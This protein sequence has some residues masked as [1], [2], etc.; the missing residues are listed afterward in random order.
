SPRDRATQV[1]WG[2][3]DFRKRFG[4][5][6]EGMWLPECAVD[7]P[8]LEALAAEGIAFSV[9]APHQAKAWRPPGG[10]WRTTA[11]D[12][13]RTYK[14]KLPSGRTIDLFFYDGATAQAVAFERLQQRRASRVES[15][16]A[17]AAARDVRLAARSRRGGA[18]CAGVISRRVGR[19]RR[20]CRG[21][22]GRS[23]RARAVPLRARD[24]RAV[25]RRT[26][27]RSLD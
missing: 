13:G 14:H 11:I 20:V 23:R 18:R 24:P 25:A 5:A 10:E 4:R 19:A 27:A 7:T 22:I 9:L 16:V 26:R 6:P 3:A 15:E 17:Q 1:K 8:S 21:F 12:P 2:I